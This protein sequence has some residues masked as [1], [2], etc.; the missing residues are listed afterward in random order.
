MKNKFNID[1]YLNFAE[2]KYSG[3]NGNGYDYSNFDSNTDLDL[4]FDGATP[5]AVA[6]AKQAAPYQVN[7][8]NATTGTLN[9]KLFGQSKYL[10]STNFGSDV[11]ITVT[12]AQSSVTYV[13]LLQQ[14]A[15]QPFET[16]L[17]RISSANT[18]Q[19]Q[20]ILEV[21]SFDA[22]GQKCTIPL[23]TQSYFSAMQFQSGIVDVPFS[24]KID[25]NTS[26]TFPVFASTTVTLTF[27]PANKA[28]I[29][30][31]LSGGATLQ[32]YAMPNIAVAS[33]P[34]YVSPRTIGGVR[35][36]NA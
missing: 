9:A 26:I 25:A 21:E 22:N 12:P 29:A 14:S 34:V 7:V 13:Q 23:I 20:A 27:F 3:A 8:T 15:S 10:L 2:R 5:M 36:L 19:V 31:Q 16:S 28:N 32:N 4:S 24:V 18:N 35:N 6:P 30:R 11:G 17:V 1:E 33:A